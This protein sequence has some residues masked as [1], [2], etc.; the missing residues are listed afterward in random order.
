MVVGETFRD[1]YLNAHKSTGSAGTTSRHDY[2][3][4]YLQSIKTSV[5]SSND[6]T[7]DMG[8]NF[9]REK[10]KP[11]VGQGFNVTTEC[12]AIAM[13]ICTRKTGKSEFIH[14]IEDLAHRE[15]WQPRDN[16]MDTWPNNRLM[17]EWLWHFANGRLDIFHWVK[18]GFETFNPMFPFNQAARQ[19]YSACIFDYKQTGENSIEAV[20]GVL[21]DGSLN[22]TVHSLQM[23]QDLKESGVYMD[24]YRWLQHLD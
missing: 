3:V 11:K 19:E 9:S 21:V 14:A 8:K 10:D 18:R 17:W 5:S 7:A 20:D 12:S 24:R 16:F 1:A 2:F 4:R 15:G 6:H 23:I 13:M 22:G